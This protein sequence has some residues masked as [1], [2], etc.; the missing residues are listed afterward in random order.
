[1]GDG[2]GGAVNNQWDLGWAFEL[3]DVAG[4]ED[5]FTP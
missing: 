1:M 4:G 5:A 2:G 3:H